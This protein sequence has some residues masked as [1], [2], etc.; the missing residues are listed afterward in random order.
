[1]TV[2]FNW[3]DL[4]GGLK[5]ALVNSP[6]A[7]A[8]LVIGYLVI[9]LVWRLRDRRWKHLS[10]WTNEVISL[11]G[12]LMVVVVAAGL[13]VFVMPLLLF[14]TYMKVTGQLPSQSI[15]Y[16]SVLG[17]SVV[18][19]GVYW[20]VADRQANEELQARYLIA[21]FLALVLLALNPAISSSSGQFFFL[22]A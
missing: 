15:L 10:N 22:P 17:L 19:I 5:S 4:I 8:A 11:V 1:M 3:D 2:S 7:D 12:W 18:G 21:L 9:V 13:L 6:V 16:L 14:I 20:W